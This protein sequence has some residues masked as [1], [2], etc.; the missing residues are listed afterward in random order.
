MHG[1]STRPQSEQGTVQALQRPDAEPLRRT[2]PEGRGF[3]RSNALE[4]A[5]NAR[6]SENQVDGLVAQLGARLNGIEKVKGS[7][8]FRSTSIR[9]V[10]REKPL[11]PERASSSERVGFLHFRYRFVMNTCP[12][13]R[14]T[15]WTSCSVSFCEALWQGSSK[16][17][18]AS[19]S[20]SDFVTYSPNLTDC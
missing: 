16:R 6:Y 18:V 14:Y 15:L 5:V 9:M 2:R 8:P 13:L 7:N 19:A 10:T 17:S 1:S 20:A 11:V 12:E 4:V 3:E